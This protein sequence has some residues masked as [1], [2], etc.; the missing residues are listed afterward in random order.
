MGDHEQGSQA[1]QSFVLR[2]WHTGAAP[3]FDV[4]D[5][6]QVC[7]QCTSP[8]ETANKDGGGGF[9]LE[10]CRRVS[11]GGAG[12]WGGGGGNNNQSECVISPC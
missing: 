7:T 8:R 12:R 9:G 11:G 4:R 10:Q 3:P 5:T 2:S 6:S 1:W